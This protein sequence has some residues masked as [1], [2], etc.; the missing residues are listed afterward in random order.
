MNTGWDWGDLAFGSK[1]PVNNLKAAFIAAPREL[2][3]AR[4]TQLVK[5]YL[6]KGNI[7]LGLAKEDYVLGFEDQPQF[8][9]LQRKSVQ[10]VIDKVNNSPSKHRIATLVYAQRDLLHVINGLDIRQFIG[11]NGSWKYSFH[12]Q[13]PYYALIQRSIPYTLVSPFADEAEA[14]D[15]AKRTKLLRPPA[16][17]IFDERQMLDIAAQA[18]KQSYDYSFQ[19]GT[20]LGRKKGNKYALLATTCN[21]VVPYQTYAMH[22]GAARETNFSPPHDIN[23]YD[24]VHAE[25]GLIIKAQKENIDLMGTTLFINLLP[26]PTCARMLSQTDIAEFVYQEDHSDGYAIKM[27]ELAG[28]KV[29]RTV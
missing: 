5:E 1:K 23:H 25:V 7:I 18:A 12:T 13:A 24:T 3:A 15:Y 29:R 10:S 27:L 20:S 26:C 4:F 8:A 21:P 22:H 28:K 2:S 19:T 16:R 11:V 17:G 6:P 14:Q 9:T